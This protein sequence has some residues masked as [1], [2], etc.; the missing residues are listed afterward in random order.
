LQQDKPDAVRQIQYERQFK[1][2]AR[3]NYTDKDWQMYR[4]AYVKLAERVDAQIAKILKAVKDAGLDDDTVIM[5]VSDHGDM[6]ASHRIEHKTILYEQAC[7]VPFMIKDPDSKFK[8]IVDTTH[9]ISTGLDI[10]PTICDYAGV[11][12]PQDIKGKSIKPIIQQGDAPWREIVHVE[13]QHGDAYIKEDCKYIKYFTGVNSEQL[14]H[15]ATNPGEM[16]ND[17]SNPKFQSALQ[18]IKSKI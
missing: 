8:N 2:L 5:F 14:V 15:S 13:G 4:W 16:W 17:I 10:L 11:K 9:M 12:P 3:E 6:D 7:R 1:K 18:Y